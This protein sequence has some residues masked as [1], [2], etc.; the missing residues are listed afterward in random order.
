MGLQPKRNLLLHQPPA[1]EQKD[2]VSNTIEEKI[3]LLSYFYTS[4]RDISWL[5]NVLVS[6]DFKGKMAKKV[7]NYHYDYYYYPKAILES[8]F[9][10]PRENRR[11]TAREYSGV[12]D[13]GN[14]LDSATSCLS[15]C[16]R[17][18]RS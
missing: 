2:N 9:Q 13:S 18:T 8:E 3:S 10:I 12:R 17:S 4:C 14:V 16:S 15:V 5:V 1:C 7:S 6:T 11:E